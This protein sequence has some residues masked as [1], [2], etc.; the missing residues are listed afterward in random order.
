MLVFGF[1]L[2][3]HSGTPV[4]GMVPPTY[5]VCLPTPPEPQRL[6]SM[7]ILN[8]MKLTKKDELSYLSRVPQ[9]T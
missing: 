6:V 9:M 4:H 8:P 1:L 3:I 7:V 2:L 5:R